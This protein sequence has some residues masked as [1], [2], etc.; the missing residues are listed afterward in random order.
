MCLFCGYYCASCV[1]GEVCLRCL[2]GYWLDRGK[3]DLACPISRYP[4]YDQVGFCG[5]CEVSCSV[6]DAFRC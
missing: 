4:M 2:E 5:V 6:C 1:D 3:C